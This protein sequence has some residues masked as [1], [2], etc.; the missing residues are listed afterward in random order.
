MMLGFE[1]VLKARLIAGY[2]DQ[3]QHFG[4]AIFGSTTPT[5]LQCD[6]LDHANIPGS[7]RYSG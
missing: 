6:H 3:D 7:T 4:E 2:W 5:C 1:Q